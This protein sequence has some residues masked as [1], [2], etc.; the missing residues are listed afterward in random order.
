MKTFI[1]LLGF[2]KIE[3]RGKNEIDARAKLKNVN[4]KELK[5]LKIESV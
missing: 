5:L 3:V 2:G 1:F 4:Q